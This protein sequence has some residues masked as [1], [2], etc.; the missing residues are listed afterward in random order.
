MRILCVDF[1]EARVG[2]A[3][4][5]VMETI[6]TGI[7]TEKVTGIHNASDKTAAVAAECGAEMILIGLPVRTDGSKGDKVERVKSFAELVREKTH[8]PIEFTDE[9]F[10]TMLAHKLLNEANI[11]S[12][13]RR[14]VIDTVS[15][16]VILQSYIDRKKNTLL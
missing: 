3:K 1:G 8:L 6:A 7:G 9:R 14:G 11:K 10:S 5:D 15:A 12:R 16:Q 13:K 2:F 4:C